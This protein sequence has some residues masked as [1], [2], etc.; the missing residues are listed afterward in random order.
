MASKKKDSRNISKSIVKERFRP[1]LNDTFSES[2]KILLVRLQHSLPINH[3]EFI[4][5]EINETKRLYPNYLSELETLKY[6]ASLNVL[7][8]LSLQGWEFIIDEEGLTL[9]MESEGQKE[10]EQIKYRLGAETSAQFKT[11]SV[12]AFIK[13]ME[14]PRCGFRR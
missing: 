10:K 14:R 8:D 6:L 9:R 13:M 11:N 7:I 12:R 1:V 4:D 2:F 3:R 5:Q